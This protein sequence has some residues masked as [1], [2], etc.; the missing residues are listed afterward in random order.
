MAHAWM[1]S[2]WSLVALGAPTPARADDPPLPEGV[3]PIDVGQ[4]EAAWDGAA[5]EITTGAEGAW[6]TLEAKVRLAH[7]NWSWRTE[8][9]WV[10]AL[11]S[12]DLAL[13]IPREA[14]LHDEARRWVSSLDVTVHGSVAVAGR[15]MMPA[16]WLLFAAG[17][18]QVPTVLSRTE[19]EEVAPLGTTGAVAGV[20]AGRHGPPIEEPPWHP[21]P[22]E[23][24]GRGSP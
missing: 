13:G 5:V 14:F 22:A 15:G 1:E 18:D 6:V 3:R 2:R 21:M 16:R 8:P 10:E 11:S 17:P 19:R 24:E 9:R 20:E 7:L 23:D 4:A 12:T